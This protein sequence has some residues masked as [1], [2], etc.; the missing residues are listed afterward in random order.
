MDKSFTY[1]ISSQDRTNT[2]LPANGATLYYDIDFGGFSEQYEDYM[3]EVISFALTA[4]TPGTASY[5]MFCAEKLAENGYFCKNKLSPNECILSVVP[6]SAAQ[7]S[8]IQSDGS[9]IRFRV[10]KCRVQRRITFFFLKPDFTQA[11]VGTDLN[12]GGVET[13]WLLTLK[14]TPIERGK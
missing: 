9:N 4:G 10:N 13:R 7:D 12:I 14:M 2:T 3:C 1:I 6:L 11:I 5:L 8:F